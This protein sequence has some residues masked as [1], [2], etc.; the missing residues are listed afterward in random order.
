MIGLLVLLLILD[1]PTFTQH[2]K[3]MFSNIADFRERCRQTAPV[4]GFLSYD[5][6]FGDDG[7]VE[8][9][10][11]PQTTATTRT[12]SKHRHSVDEAFL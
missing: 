10:S 1:I 7:S 4:N 3:I 9:I 11:V 5:R 2:F 6:P 12:P 8:D